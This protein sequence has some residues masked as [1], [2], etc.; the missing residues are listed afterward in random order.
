[1]I[2]SMDM[3]HLEA[4]AMMAQV[5]I[6]V[7]RDVALF[8]VTFLQPISVCNQTIS[9]LRFPIMSTGVVLTVDGR[10]RTLAF[11]ALVSNLGGHSKL[12]SLLKILATGSGAPVDISHT[13]ES[14]RSEATLF[15]D[16]VGS[17]WRII[18]YPTY[19]RRESARYGSGLSQTPRYLARPPQ[20]FPVSGEC[21]AQSGVGIILSAY[22]RANVMILLRKTLGT[23]SMR[24]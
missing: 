20:L 11:P 2:A 10:H 3:L 7:F 5:L 6:L 14:P 24:S 9:M 1:V 12:T 18:P 13:W 22:R 23:S 16:L 8:I 17:V 15:S 19:T 4:S 21:V